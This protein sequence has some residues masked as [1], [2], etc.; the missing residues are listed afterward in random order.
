MKDSVRV[1][2][3]KWRDYRKNHDFLNPSCL[4]ALF[5]PKGDVL[6]YNEAAIYLPLSGRYRGE[7]VAECAKGSCG[8]LGESLFPPKLDVVTTSPS[9]P[10]KALYEAWAPSEAL[11]KKK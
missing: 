10:G 9:T 3:D 5:Q 2:P 6:R 7:W 1:S 4:C 8:Y 11:P